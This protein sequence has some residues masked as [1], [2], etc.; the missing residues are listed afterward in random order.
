MAQADYAD[1][2]V[3]VEKRPAGQEEQAR[4]PTA[5]AR[6]PAR[7][8]VHAMRP[9]RRPLDPNPKP[10]GA[11]TVDPAAGAAG[12]GA[13]GA[14]VVSPAP[15]GAGARPAAVL[16]IATISGSH[17]HPGKVLVAGYLLRRVL[18]T[19]CLFTAPDP[20]SLALLPAVS[21]QQELKI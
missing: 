13:Q 4:S 18:I 3:A 16:L 14:S 12:A 17:R 19:S 2:P 8:A 6:V 20:R 21:L 10:Q 15:N 11:H 1:A 9:N 7:H 5:G